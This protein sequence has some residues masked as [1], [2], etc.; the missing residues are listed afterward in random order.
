MKKYLFAALLALLPFSAIATPVVTTKTVTIQPGQS[1]PFLS[2]FNVSDLGSV[3]QYQVWQTTTGTGGAFVVGGVSLPART[4]ETITSAQAATA[5]FLAGTLPETNLQIRAYDGDW[6]NCDTC[7]WQ[8]FP[9]WLTG[10]YTPT[11]G[12]GPSGTGGLGQIGANLNQQCDSADTFLDWSK[13]QWLD[14]LGTIE[15]VKMFGSLGTDFHPTPGNAEPIGQYLAGIQ[16]W[17]GGDQTKAV[18]IFVQSPEVFTTGAG[19]D[20][21]KGEE[22]YSDPGIVVHNGDV[23]YFIANC[24][25]PYEASPG[26]NWQ[27][28]LEVFFKKN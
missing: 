10:T 4:V 26:F 28:D 22:N 1:V 16:L 19:S 13:T 20:W 27:E 2:L 15:I 18:T 14:N 21:W 9:V 24:F 23:L 17:P 25:N 8:P 7:S 3:T 5:T 11:G 12:V 6:S